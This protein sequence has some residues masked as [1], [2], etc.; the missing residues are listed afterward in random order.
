M[1]RFNYTE[2]DTL[3][4]EIRESVERLM[5]DMAFDVDALE[6]KMALRSSGGSYDGAR[7]W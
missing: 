2:L 3:D 5:E 6:C 1:R 7:K 4:P